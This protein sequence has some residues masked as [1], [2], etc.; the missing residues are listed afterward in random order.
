MFDANGGIKMK[1][2]RKK[3]RVNKIRLLGS[4]AVL[5]ILIIISAISVYGAVN[6]GDALNS[7]NMCTEY[8]LI[9]V[10]E[11]DSVWSIA[12]VFCSESKDVRKTVDAICYINSIE[13]YI[14]YPGQELLIPDC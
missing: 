9:E 12:K 5:T 7:N 1:N 4:L 11:G 8:K 14:I 6:G 2:R 13:D 3:Y 10:A